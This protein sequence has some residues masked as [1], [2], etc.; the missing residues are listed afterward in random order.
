MIEAT[1]KRA[2]VISDPL[3]IGVFIVYHR[4]IPPFALLGLRQQ[5]NGNN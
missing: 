3:A 5:S 4:L 2:R 1:Q